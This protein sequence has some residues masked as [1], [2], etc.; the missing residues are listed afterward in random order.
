MSC[1]IR[2][3]DYHVSPASWSMSSLLRDRLLSLLVQGLGS[4]L[5]LYYFMQS[6]AATGQT[7]VLQRKNRR[8]LIY[9]KEGAFQGD[10]A[11]WLIDLGK[12]LK[13]PE[14]WTS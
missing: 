7:V 3:A 5:F 13:E 9:S 14:C 4:P 1:R 6:L 2:S 10:E 8:T 12:Y 11:G